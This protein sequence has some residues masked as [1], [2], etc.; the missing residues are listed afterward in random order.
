[1]N[2]RER[3]AQQARD[4]RTQTMA[5]TP[6]DPKVE[7]ITQGIYNMLEGLLTGQKR[8]VIVSEA[9]PD[10]VCVYAGTQ[11]TD[12]EFTQVVHYKHTFKVED[13]DNVG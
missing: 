1:M 6:K 8:L 2:R 13:C 3:L 4:R 10:Q 7:E 12:P 9:T 11:T 5:D